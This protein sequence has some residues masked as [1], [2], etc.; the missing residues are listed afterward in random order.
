M[1]RL[2]HATD[3]DAIVAAWLADGPRELPAAARHSITRQVETSPQR[4][5]G[6]PGWGLLLAAAAVLIL[7]V[8][9]TYGLARYIGE[10]PR[11]TNVVEGARQSAILV[12]PE[13]EIAFT[14][15]VPSGVDFS[16]DRSLNG[17][18]TENYSPSGVMGFTVGGPGLYG[19]RNT[20]TSSTFVEGAR[21][22]VVAD[23]TDAV[24]L[25]GEPESE[26][27]DDP[28]SFLSSL[29]A[30]T[31]FEARDI[32]EE[33]LGELRAVS[34]TVVMEREWYSHLDLAGPSGSGSVDFYHPSRV[35]VAQVGEA[36]V[37]VQV[38][39]ETEDEMTAW[40]PTAME[41]IDTLEFSTER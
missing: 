19:W 34:A 30:T 39:A 24:V 13:R 18:P 7:A 37:L 16:V 40:L 9:A 3:S 20:A 26:L 28:M 23:V 29:D 38:W 35:F 11:P 6:L 22:I 31:V 12:G 32:E 21:G 17:S 4:P 27:G 5:A 33:W 25:H 41:F 2:T 36:L 15:R 14:Y 1:T 10:M 8:V